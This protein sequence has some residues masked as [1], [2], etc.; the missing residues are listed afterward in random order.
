[1]YIRF[2]FSL[3]SL[4]I[5]PQIV[6]KRGKKLNYTEAAKIADLVSAVLDVEYL[7]Y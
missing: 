2:I 7:E 5:F 3:F 6:L 4:R 1:M